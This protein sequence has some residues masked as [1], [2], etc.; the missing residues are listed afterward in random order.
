MARTSQ[1]VRWFPAQHVIENRS[2]AS[3]ADGARP[4][5]LALACLLSSPR[6]A[7]PGDRPRSTVSRKSATLLISSATRT[8]E[9]VEAGHCDEQK[10]AG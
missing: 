10:D 1:I 2:S 9:T 8:Y 6:R 4:A 5:A 7:R 3:Q